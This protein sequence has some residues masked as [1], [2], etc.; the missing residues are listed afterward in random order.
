MWKNSSLSRKK[1]EQKD[2]E[3]VYTHLH[4]DL[5]E[6]PFIN[7]QIFIEHLLGAKPCSENMTV[8]KKKVT[9]SPAIVAWTETK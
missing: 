7:R 3:C 4:T 8:K 6:Y 5:E 9:K 2:Y 1:L